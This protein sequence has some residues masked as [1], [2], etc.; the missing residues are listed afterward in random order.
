MVLSRH[1]VINENGGVD[2]ALTA[3]NTDD[4]RPLLTQGLQGSLY[5]DHISKDLLRARCKR[6]YKVRKNMDPL[7]FRFPMS[8]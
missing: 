6:V 1:L 2:V 5:G 8:C 4:R 3:G 7:D